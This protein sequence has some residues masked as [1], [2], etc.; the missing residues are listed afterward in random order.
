MRP[1][2]IAYCTDL[3]PEQFIPRRRVL[4]DELKNAGHDVVYLRSAA[5]LLE[6][7]DVSSFDVGLLG[8]VEPK[9]DPSGEIHEQDFA[10]ACAVALL[11]ERQGLPFLNSP[12][13]RPLS[14]DKLLAQAAFAVAK[15]PQ[16]RTIGLDPEG[17]PEDFP[18]P[19]V[20]KPRSG[21]VGRGV[22][23]VASAKEAVAHA[24]SLQ[25]PCLLQEP[26]AAARCVRVTASRSGV[27][28]RLEK[29]MP[30][31]EFVAAFYLGAE[32]VEVAADPTLDG[33]AQAMVTATG[34]QVAGVD[35]L[36]DE[37]GR[38]YALEVNADFWFDPDDLTLARW[39][40]SLVEDAARVRLP[41]QFYDA[42]SLFSE[43]MQLEFANNRAKGEEWPSVTA[44]DRLMDVTYH[45]GKLAYQLKEGT[46]ERILELAADTANELVL[47]TVA[48]G[49]LSREILESR[50]AEGD[51]SVQLE[52][53][54]F[55]DNRIIFPRREAGEG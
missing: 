32:P 28:H 54:Q 48:A 45:F 31:G 16:P 27:F 23:L 26:V 42:L 22:L 4:I 49:A 1:L 25:E 41:G 30:R 9:N 52:S 29:H 34:N 43:A 20:V 5:D 51:D 12:A 6:G 13:A 19:A 36:I 35:I 2:R 33:L 38:M 44:H 7:V 10:E 55:R 50:R 37:K 39:L 15:L 18:F 8:T 11:L 47:M 14:D 24:A 3:R 46:P 17:P 53:A 21:M 40:V